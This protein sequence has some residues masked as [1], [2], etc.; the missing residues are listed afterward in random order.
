MAHCQSPQSP[1]GTTGL[2]PGLGTE[3]DTQ[4]L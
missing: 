2:S 4:T 3:G 1:P